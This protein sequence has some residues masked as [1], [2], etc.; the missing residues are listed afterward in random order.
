[1]K[2]WGSGEVCDPKELLQAA[3]PNIWSR[4]LLTFPVL[5]VTKSLPRARSPV[6]KY[7]GR[8][9]PQDSGN[10]STFATRVIV[11]T[12]GACCSTCL[13]SESFLRPPKSQDAPQLRPQVLGCRQPKLCCLASQRPPRVSNRR[14]VG[15]LVAMVSL[16]LRTTPGWHHGFRCEFLLVPL[17]CLFT[18]F[19]H[20]LSIKGIYYIILYL[21]SPKKSLRDC[22]CKEKA[23]F[24]L[25]TSLPLYRYSS[26][27]LEVLLQMQKGDRQK[28]A[29]R[30]ATS[31]PVVWL[32]H[33]P[34]LCRW[35]RRGA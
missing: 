10:I 20:L 34:K 21:L 27:L 24:V 17:L 18:S 16:D 2:P 35:L 30:A 14:F 1:M 33:D 28:W 25:L 5:K 4:E 19:L 29:A 22:R 26:A 7:E 13:G 6:L 31:T 32:S 12:G 9:I 23:L 8:A 15:L 3:W 11:I